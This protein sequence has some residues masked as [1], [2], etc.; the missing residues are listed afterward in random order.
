MYRCQ[1]DIFTH[2]ATLGQNLVYDKK[3]NSDNKKPQ[4]LYF[5][6]NLQKYPLKLLQKPIKEFVEGLTLHHDVPI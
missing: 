6:E 3:Y 1:W 5:H 4:L 2:K